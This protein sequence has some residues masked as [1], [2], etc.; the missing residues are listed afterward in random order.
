MNHRVTGW[1]HDRRLNPNLFKHRDK[2]EALL[3]G[4]EEIEGYSIV[5]V[6]TLELQ[7][8]QKP[9]DN[10]TSF[11]IELETHDGSWIGYIAV[12]DE[13]VEETLDD[14]KVKFRKEQ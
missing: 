3:D 2:V 4:L 6:Y 10:W 8:D 11:E 7:H 13:D 14:Y 12:S 5:Q 1:D 9:G